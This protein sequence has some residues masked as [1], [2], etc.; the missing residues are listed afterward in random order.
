MNI[1]FIRK[2]LKGDLKVLIWTLIKISVGIK[3]EH[4]HEMYHSLIKIYYMVPKALTL[5]VPT[6]QNGQTCSNNSSAV[7]NCLSMLD[8]FVRL[9]L[10][11]LTNYVDNKTTWKKSHTVKHFLR[12][13]LACLKSPYFNVARPQEKYTAVT[14]MPHFLVTSIANE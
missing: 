7:A 9:V 3:R 1:F 12:S 10:K 11:G 13:S 2:F 8:Y 5:Q 6:L 4:W 14:S